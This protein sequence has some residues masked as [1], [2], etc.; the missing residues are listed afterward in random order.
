MTS[1]E[2][3]EIIFNDLFVRAD[4]LNEDPLHGFLVFLK[5]RVKLTA[6]AHPKR[7]RGG[8]RPVT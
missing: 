8:R 7:R 6:E 3:D 5:R 2:R 4:A 1:A